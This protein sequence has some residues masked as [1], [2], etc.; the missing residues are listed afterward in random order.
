MVMEAADL[1][2]QVADFLGFRNEQ[3]LVGELVQG[4]SGDGPFIDEILGI[5]DAL[6][7]I[8]GTAVDRDA[9]VSGGDKLPF[10]FRDG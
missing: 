2:E 3:G 7:L 5:N 10:G 1:F 4:L 6:D 9:A 8:Y